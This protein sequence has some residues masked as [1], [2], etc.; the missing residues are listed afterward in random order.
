MAWRLHDAVIRGEIDN[1]I[2]GKVTGRIW[3]AG[4][5]EPVVLELKGDGHPD[6]A[7]CIL[8]FTNPRP[9]PDDRLDGFRLLQSGQAG[10]LTASR[11]VRVPTVSTEEF[12]R[13]YAA[14]LPI[15]TKWANSIYLEWFSE[16]NGRVVIESADY[17]CSISEPTWRLTEDDQA[18]QQEQ[19][20][21]AMADFMQRIGDAPATPSKAEEAGEPDAGEVSEE[22]PPTEGSDWEEHQHMDEFQAERFLKEC[23]E[24]TDRYLELLEKYQDDP[25][26]DRL[27]A[28]EMGWTHIL[29]AMDAEET[30]EGAPSAE[31][32]SGEE[33][34][35]E[36][37]GDQGREEPGGSDP[38]SGQH[39]HPVAR[40]AHDLVRRLI[41]DQKERGLLQG[42]R[43]E[44]AEDRMVGAAMSASAKL[45]GA[46]NRLE[47]DEPPFEPGLTVAWLKRALMFQHEAI[48]GADAALRDFP[49]RGGWLRAVRNELMMVRQETL[50]LME[51]YRRMI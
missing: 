35:T 32:E 21:A 14:R 3:F 51:H 38:F 1:R 8:T 49:E 50:N 10:D 18:R 2:R 28:R 30:G 43:E 17:Q 41:D 31:E 24:R 7:G 22:E 12:R 9:E 36:S 27:V 20:S 13:L 34:W 5:D 47:E 19:A 48:A 26:R 29:E 46:L 39:E 6:L 40:R 23:D 11:K 25:D 44:T 37:T 15:P 33:S 42:E 16:A 4:L 45:A